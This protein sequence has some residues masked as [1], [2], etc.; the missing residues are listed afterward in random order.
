M[1]QTNVLCAHRTNT[2]SYVAFTGTINQAPH[3]WVNGPGLALDVAA[4]DISS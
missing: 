2:F 3:Q 4:A 1:I